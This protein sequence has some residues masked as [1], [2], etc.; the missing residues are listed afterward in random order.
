MTRIENQIIKLTKEI[1]GIQNLTAVKLAR[2]DF[3][4]KNFYTGIRRLIYESDKIRPISQKLYDLL[5]KQL[6]AEI[7]EWQEEP[8]YTII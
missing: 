3:E 1:E 7:K 8:D 4:D 6:D 2:K 5:N